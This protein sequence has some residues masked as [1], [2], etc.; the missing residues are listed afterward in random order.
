MP[1]E[2]DP[3]D[4]PIDPTKLVLLVDLANFRPRG[5]A[6]KVFLQN[7]PWWTPGKK[8]RTSLQYIDGCLSE[9][10][11]QAPGSIIISFCDQSVKKSLDDS[12]WNELERRGRLETSDSNKVFFTQSKRADDALTRA[13]DAFEAPIISHD[14]FRAEGYM[15]LAFDQSFDVRTNTFR[16]AKM[17]NGISIAMQLS[18]W[19]ANRIGNLN[20]EW[21]QS[22]ERDAAEYF[23]RQGVINITFDLLL[24]E[25]VTHNP[26]VPKNAL[27]A[28]ETRKSERSA[29]R[30]QRRDDVHVRARSMV[31]FTQPETVLY[32]DEWQRMDEFQGRVVTLVG[33]LVTTEDGQLIEW[34]RNYRPISVV[35]D[36]IPAI[37]GK[38]R[39]AVVTGRLEQSDGELSIHLDPAQPNGYRWF[40]DVVAGRPIY[41]Q[42]EDPLEDFEPE[43]WRFPSFLPSLRFVRRLRAE[44]LQ[45]HA[46]Q[47]FSIQ[48]QEP[49]AV[50][51]RYEPVTP[52]PKAPDVVTPPSEKT[53]IDPPRRELPTAAIATPLPKEIHVPE[54]SPAVRMPSVISSS[55]SPIT[56][57]ESVT[58]VGSD[59]AEINGAQPSRRMRKLLVGMA[60][61]AAAVATAIAR[62]VL[63]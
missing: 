51:P 62:Y 30:E 25:K 34:F 21:L 56:S 20:A 18:D 28:L 47:D 40:A 61:A 46:H 12:D 41:L 42:D 33:R 15:G 36:V 32:A 57:S 54:N 48:S 4:S 24:E 8:E 58:I 43:H 55:S 22:S 9:L 13:A 11:H 19:W 5:D 6:R 49:V 14:K 17:E 1:V 16:F 27:Q 38:D 44:R 35:G 45:E 59:E 7:V 26:I 29:R 53:Q 60:I 50:A 3:A 2:S 39:F 63:F 10:E 31:E 37:Y 52:T 23:M